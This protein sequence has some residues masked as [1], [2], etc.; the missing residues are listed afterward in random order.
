MPASRRL[1]AFL[2]AALLAVA[3]LAA[4]SPA[5]A[6]SRERE[7]GRKAYEQIIRIYGLYEDQ[8]VQDYVSEIGQR[9]VRVSDMPGEEW[10]FVVLDE[11]SINAFTTGC[12][13]VYIH[14]GLL[15]YLNSE[16]ELASVL[17]H[18]VAHVTEK[19]PQKRKTQG[20]LAGLG[21]MA[22]AIATGSGA[23]AQ[24]ANLGANAW[25]QGYGRENEMEADRVGLVYAMKAGYRPEAMGEVFE[26]FKDQERFELDRARAEGRQPRI[27]HGIFSS[28]PA[29]DARLIQ[30]ARSSANVGEGPPGGWIDN[31]DEYLSRIDGMPFGTSRAQG[32]VR[33]NRFYH[34][35]MGITMAFPRGWRIENLRDRLIAVSGS[36]D[37]VMQ[38]T[39]DPR[40]PTRS[41]R[42]FLLER[43]KGQSIT[44]GEEIRT[45]DM[46]GYSLVTRGGSPLDGGRGPVRWIVLYRD[47]SAYVFA[48]ASRASVSGKPEAD[49]LFRSVAETMRGLRPS[50]FPLAEPHRIRVVEYDARMQL[51]DLAK[52]V[53]VAKYQR[54]ELLLMNGLYPN[55]TPKVG[56]KIKIVQ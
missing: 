3:A 36:R 8:A 34:A 22:A 42:E 43:L 14:R 12:C 37:S 26:V 44:G 23:V 32:S 35:D 38:V 53:P 51:D 16:A 27:Y 21:A 20:I 18:E 54:E 13:Y 5:S 41:P 50:E 29:P 45:N 9:I 30:A 33:D 15:T 10:V 19:H 40:P 7:A 52:D 31:R 1:A 47:Q 49:G 25:I 39:V 55:R 11:E 48:G 24:L 17:G 46:E 6:Q 56:D 28:H 4:A 2:P